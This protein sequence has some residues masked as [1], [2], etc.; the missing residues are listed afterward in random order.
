MAL[1]QRMLAH[2]SATVGRLRVTPGPVVDQNLIQDQF[3]QD[4]GKRYKP[5][6]VGYDK[7]NATTFMLQLRDQYKYTVVEVPQ[8]RA[9]SESFKLFYALVRLKRILHDGNPVMGWCV[10]NAEPKRDRY[11]NLWIEKPSQTKRIDGLIAAVIALS[12]LVLLPARRKPKRRGA[13][14]YTSSGFVPAL[15]PSQEAQ[16]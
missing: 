7:Y 8:G 10:S 4:I 11:E 9:L 15:P 12:Q 16:P 5:D 6:R 2:E 1:A 14:I 13:M 3:V